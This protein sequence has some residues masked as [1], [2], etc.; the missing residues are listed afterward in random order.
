MN[1]KNFTK[2]WL[3][4][5]FSPCLF[6]N[7]DVEIGIKYYKAGDTDKNHYHK[8]ATEYTIIISGEV[9]MQN[10]VFTSGDIITI[11]PNIEN[12]FDCLKDACILVIKTPSL[13]NDKY[14]I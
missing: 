13:I 10:K 12:I 3:V 7:K 8:I 1:I 14:F 9:K 4:G 6:N 5:D 11:E 2:G